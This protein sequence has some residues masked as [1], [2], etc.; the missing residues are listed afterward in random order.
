[1]AGS[2]VSKRHGS[3]DFSLMTQKNPVQT[4]RAFEHRVEL[5]EKRSKLNGMDKPDQF[6]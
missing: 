4:N 1:M 2:T 6:E 5:L 3:I